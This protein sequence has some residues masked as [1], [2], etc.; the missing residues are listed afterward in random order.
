MTMKYLFA[1]VNLIRPL[2]CVIGALTIV[3][4]AV[5]TRSTDQRGLMMLGGL[6]VFLYNAGANAI[7][8]YYDYAT[9][10]INRPRRPIASGLLSRKTGLWTSVVL[11]SLGSLLALQLP[12][13]AMIVAILLAL[14]LLVGYSVLLKGRPLV[15]NLTVAFIL[16][17]VFVFGGLIFGDYQTMLIPATLAFVLTVLRELIKDM[18][19]V[20]GDREQG[21]RTFPVVAGLPRSAALV[22]VIAFITGILMLIPSWFGIYNDIYLWIVLG[23]IH[24]PLLYILN[25]FHSGVA[26]P[27]VRFAAQLLK[28]STIAGVLAVYMGSL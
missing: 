2:N 11:F 21:L 25:Q 12:V 10:R 18:E 4:T 16:G 5:L 7:N 20:R 28:F 23:G 1:L 22:R 15:G 8:D 13:P 19:D 24:L 3:V 6:V 17:L 26:V 9:D 14:P 27:S